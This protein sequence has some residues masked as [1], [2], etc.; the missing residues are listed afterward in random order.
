MSAP[1]HW[2]DQS[3]EHRSTVPMCGRRRTDADRIKNYSKTLAE[4]VLTAEGWS[5]AANGSTETEAAKNEAGASSPIHDDDDA[6]DRYV[7]AAVAMI[8]G[9]QFVKAIHFYNRWAVLAG[10]ATVSIIAD[11]PVVIDIRDALIAVRGEDFEVI[12]C[13]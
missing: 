8:Q 13:R 5:S 4:W 12:L 6:H 9:G 1:M 3:M 11:N 10:Y 7:G 2:C